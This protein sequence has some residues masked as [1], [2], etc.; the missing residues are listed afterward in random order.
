MVAFEIWHNGRKVCT[1]GVGKYGWLTTM[2]RR[3]KPHKNWA[4]AGD[5]CTCGARRCLTCGDG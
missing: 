3:R 1:M 2:A 5:F 4:S